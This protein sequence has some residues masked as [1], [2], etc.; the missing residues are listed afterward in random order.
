MVPWGLQHALCVLTTILC[1]CRVHW[2]GTSTSI[3]IVP[4]LIMPVPIIFSVLFG[5]GNILCFGG[6]LY[7]AWNP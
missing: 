1:N 2:I 7:V 3:S 6:I 4:K 5:I